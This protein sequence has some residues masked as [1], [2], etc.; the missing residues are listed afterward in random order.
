MSAM[1]DLRGSIKNVPDIYYAQ[2][3]RVLVK[4]GKLIAQGNLKRMRYSEVKLP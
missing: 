2:R 4:E 1:Q 3:I